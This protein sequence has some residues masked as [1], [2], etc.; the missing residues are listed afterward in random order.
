M[1][2]EELKPC[3]F[4]GGKAWIGISI[5]LCQ[6]QCESCGAKIKGKYKDRLI[7]AWN[8]RASEA[9]EQANSAVAK[10]PRYRMFLSGGLAWER[11][12]NGAWVMYSDLQTSSPSGSEGK[13]CPNCERPIRSCICMKV[14]P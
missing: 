4:C 10:I 9:G 11:D 2:R 3:P 1:D 8:K 6:I 7:E 14:K 5:E 12:D 13:L